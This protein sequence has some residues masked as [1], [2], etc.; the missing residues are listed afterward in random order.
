[1]QAEDRSLILKSRKQELPVSMLM[2]EADANRHCGHEAVR[3]ILGSRK[4]YFENLCI[5][6]ILQA[7]SSAAFFVYESDL[8]IFMPDFN[9][10]MHLNVIFFYLF[11]II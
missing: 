9:G 1:M 5:T 3:I 2:Q 6:C 8:W 7:A 10:K 4:L 11:T